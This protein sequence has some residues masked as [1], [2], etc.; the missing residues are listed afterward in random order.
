MKEK[1]EHLATVS[2]KAG[3]AEYGSVY[4]RVRVNGQNKKYAVGFTIKEI[5]WLKYRSL[6]YVSSHLIS[7]LGIRYAVFAE[8]LS[9]IKIN[10]ETN[11]NAST[12]INLTLKDQLRSAQYALD[13]V[14]G[15]TYSTVMDYEIEANEGYEDKAF[16]KYIW[17]NC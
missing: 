5:E 3:M 9:Q 14:N 2:T 13:N 7:S 16:R 10:L 12:K 4:A 17:R 15:T 1:K 6:Q 8:V 11:F